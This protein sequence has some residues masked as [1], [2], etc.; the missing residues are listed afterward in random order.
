MADTRSPKEIREFDAKKKKFWSHIQKKYQLMASS[1]ADKKLIQDTIDWEIEVWN[2]RNPKE[3]HY[4]DLHLMSARGALDYVERIEAAKR[5]SQEVTIRLETGRG[6][7]SRN[8]VPVI[9]S[10]LLAKYQQHQHCT[11]QQD[12]TNPGVLKLVIHP[13]V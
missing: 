1:A 8:K 12:C 11:I 4:Y 5:S 13:F 6:V 10:R 2:K 3:R 9:K 7:H